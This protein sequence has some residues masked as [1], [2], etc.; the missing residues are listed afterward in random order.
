[1]N[2]ENTLSRRRVLSGFGAGLAVAAV[3]PVLS[4]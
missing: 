3:G 1:M 2:E 4:A